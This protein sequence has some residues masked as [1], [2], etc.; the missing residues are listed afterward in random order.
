MPARTLAGAG[1][2]AL[3]LVC[4]LA[5]IRGPAVRQWSTVRWPDPAALTSAS[6][7]GALWYAPLLLAAHSAETL[8]IALPCTL[9][10][11]LVLATAR[12][13]SDVWR[14]AIA[15]RG[16]NLTV[17]VGPNRL[18]DVAWPPGA[19]L[20][21]LSFA[22][23]DWQLSR[24]GAVLAAGDV[25]PPAIGGFFSSLNPASSGVSVELRT[26]DYSSKPSSRQWLLHA[27]TLAF[28]LAAIGALARRS[29]ARRAPRLAPH[30][31]DAAVAGSLFVW[32]I[33]GPL[34]YD[35]GWLMA[36]VY[37]RRYS[38][39]SSNYFD[40]YGA[41]LPLGFLQHVLLLPF[42][43]ANAPLLAWR[44]LPL[45]TCLITWLLLRCALARICDEP[46]P[47]IGLVA[48]AGAYLT[49]A[50]AWLLTLRPE[51]TVAMLSAAGLL[52]ALI[53]RDTRSR[54]ALTASMVTIAIATTLHPSGLVATAPLAFLLPTLYRDIRQGVRSVV[55]L[56]SIAAV[57]A[58]AGLALLFADSDLDMWRASRAAFVGDGFHTAGF[59]DEPRRYHDLLTNGTI[60]GLA[61][62]LFSALAIAL[63]VGHLRRKGSRFNAAGLSL[64]VAGLLLC[65]TPSKWLYHFGSAAAIASLAIAVE[66]T[67]LRAP[68]WRSTAA[69]YA[70]VLVTPVVV[71]RS[72]R[73]FRDAQYFLALR[74]PDVR[75]LGKTAA[76]VA[77]ALAAVA[78][79]AAIGRAR[80]REAAA[81]WVLPI[82]LV[83]IAAVAFATRA[84]APMI[85]SPVWSAA[86][87]GLDGLRH[88]GCQ[89]AELIDV[90]DTRAARR[91]PIAP[92]TSDPGAG[93][94]ASDMRTL[95]PAPSELG[96]VAV[97]TTKFDSGATSLSSPW[98][99]VRPLDD[100]EDIVISVE[101]I[102]NH[103][104]NALSLEWGQRRGAQVTALDRVPLALDRDAR[105]VGAW[106][107]DLWRKV[108]LSRLAPPPG[109]ADLVRFVLRDASDERGHHVSVTAPFVLAHDTL[110][111]VMAGKPVLVA[112]PQQPLLTCA[113]H[114]QVHHGVAEMPDVAVGFVF[115]RAP[116]DDNSLG[117]PFSPWY[118]YAEGYPTVRLW[119]WLND[120]DAAPLPVRLPPESVGRLVPAEVSL[121]DG[122]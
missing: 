108:R 18:A 91:L 52:G 54:A 30:G 23:A 37:A 12:S 59:T 28:G 19:C 31:V 63:W 96:P 25:F 79:G 38:G 73:G 87:R 90:S 3:A 40:T 81:S 93:R 105:G 67:R 95:L 2:A 115:L 24:D 45:V 27:A 65:F 71:A 39:V 58:T 20:G 118:L 66:A 109:G 106:E 111:S 61:S 82:G 21:H 14:L 46:P 16:A 9:G 83:T 44:A 100:G 86:N 122:T 10:E 34:Y 94:A 74:P 84:V 88:G 26:H 42:A 62:V 113:R 13:T 43:N 7:T 29:A 112:P 103:F 49:F 8:D 47:L 68:G 22:G 121:R 92:V 117:G 78:I 15:R 48:L 56:G 72:L 114:V 80:G 55:E 101:G 51:P 5:A 116:F 77:L 97:Y 60:M 33:A 6:D 35:D 57:G 110:A 107:F 69:R 1:F 85:D 32:W 120:R 53:Y 17:E 99:A 102:V 76:W 64:A 36:T 98:Y 70:A 89:F 41:S 119:A 50:F 104:G 11:G 4:A 75:A